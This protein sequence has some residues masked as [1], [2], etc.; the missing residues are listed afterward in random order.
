MFHESFYLNGMSSQLHYT[1]L[2]S[3]FHELPHEN[4]V[5]GACICDILCVRGM[6]KSIQSRWFFLQA[7][8][9]DTALL[10]AVRY[11][12]ADCVRLLIDAGAE[13]NAKD[14]VHRRLRLCRGAFSFCSLYFLLS[15]VSFILLLSLLC[16]HFS[17]WRYAGLN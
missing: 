7:Q 9:E 15:F 14:Q 16:P 6:L 1:A 5:R 8:F 17:R 4:C 2:L 13:T 10:R 11:G 12:H 3:F